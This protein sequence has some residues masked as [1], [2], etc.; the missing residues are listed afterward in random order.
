MY[1]NVKKKLPSPISNPETIG[2]RTKHSN[3]GGYKPFGGLLAF[4]ENKK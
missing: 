1:L 4:F 2:A 3:Y